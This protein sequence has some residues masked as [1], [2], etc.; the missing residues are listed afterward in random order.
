M[1]AGSW[2]RSRQIPMPRRSIPEPCHTNPETS[3]Y[4]GRV[5]FVVESI[6]GKT[7]KI[8]VS[9]ESLSQLSAEAAIQAND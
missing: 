1:M 2:A 3:S 5:Q 8:V 7:G 9:V 4:R 6:W